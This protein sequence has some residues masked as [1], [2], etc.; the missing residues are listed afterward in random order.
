MFY[1]DINFAISPVIDTPSTSLQEI[2]EYAFYNTGF[3]T[4]NLTLNQ[5]II[6]SYAFAH[7]QNLTN[8]TINVAMISDHMF[9]ECPNLT[10]ISIGSNVRNT[11]SMVAAG[12]EAWAVRPY[13]FAN[14]DALTDIT[15]ANNVI[16]DYMFYDCDALL[17]VTI[18]STVEYIGT[19]TFSEC[20]ELYH[21][22]FGAIVLGTYMFTN[23]TNLLTVD[24]NEGLIEIPEYCFYKSYLTTITIPASVTKVGISAFEASDGLITAY[25]NNNIIG[26]R[27]FYDCVRLGNNTDF[28][29]TIPQSVVTVGNYAFYNCYT[30]KYILIEIML[31]Q[32]I[33]LKSVKLL[34]QL[35]F[36]VL[37]HQ[38]ENMHL[39]NVHLYLM[40]QFIQLKL[41]NI[42]SIMIQH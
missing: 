39:L 33:C 26:E 34:L 14:C 31:F 35:I 5:N 17:D 6:G 30:L 23:D 2:G 32:T 42:Y 24:L 21:V 19:Y 13:A 25:F 27:M 4:I 20:Q 1:N 7:M 36:Q 18:P 16:G 37:L 38:L 9:F 3:A 15:I 28:V 22:T 40:L 41:Q 11:S 12:S 8:T 29:L 10:T